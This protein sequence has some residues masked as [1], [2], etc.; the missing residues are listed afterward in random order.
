M[1]NGTSAERLLFI[2]SLGATLGTSIGNGTKNLVTVRQTPVKAQRCAGRDLTRKP[3]R[4]D[5]L[6]AKGRRVMN[7]DQ[8]RFWHELLAYYHR[9]LEERQSSAMVSMLAFFHGE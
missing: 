7:E 2:E 8:L 4:G 3:A 6:Q 5:G 9:G 1:R